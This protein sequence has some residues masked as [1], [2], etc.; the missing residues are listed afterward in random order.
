MSVLISKVF[1]KYQN[2]YLQFANP[3]KCVFW[4]LLIITGVLCFR[5]NIEIN[6]FFNENF[7]FAGAVSTAMIDKL[8]EETR[9]SNW[10]E[11]ER[12]LVQHWVDKSPSIFSPLT[13]AQWDFKPSEKLIG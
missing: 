11:A 7:C 12:I 3:Y 6:G 4:C 5:F 8:I 9:R 10:N 1:K 2:R 13:D